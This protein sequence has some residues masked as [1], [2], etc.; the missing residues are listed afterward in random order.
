VIAYADR[1][2]LT[3]G[4]D[5]AAALSFAPDGEISWL[6]RSLGRLPESADPTAVA[7]GALLR[8][9]RD[10]AA[11]AAE[12]PRGTVDVVGTGLVA[13]HVRRLTGGRSHSGDDA[14]A[15]VV[16]T[17]GDPETIRA[18]LDR[19]SDRGM[20]VLAGES[21]GRALDLDL[22]STVHRRGLVVVG[23]ASP[24]ES[25]DVAAWS[26]FEGDELAACRDALGDASAGTRPPGDSLWY[27]LEE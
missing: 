3:G 12:H 19:V 13:T 9:A 11:A 10:A 27:R 25:F 26:E 22:Y 7:A 8:V 18:A 5:G 15:V 16:D 6:G 2:W 1:E 17:T 23:V 4:G 20:V 21:S 24:S 14:P